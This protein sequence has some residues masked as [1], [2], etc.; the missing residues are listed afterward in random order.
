[1]LDEWLVSFIQLRLVIYGSAIVVLFL[2][3]RRGVVPTVV[4]FVEHIRRRRTP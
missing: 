1:V 2:F 3:V 4:S